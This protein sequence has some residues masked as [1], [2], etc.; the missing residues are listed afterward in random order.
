MADMPIEILNDNPVNRLRQLLLDYDERLAEHERLTQLLAEMDTTI[1]LA[2]MTLSNNVVI[3]LDAQEDYHKFVHNLYLALDDWRTKNGGTRIAPGF[4]D[5]CFQ[6]A[7]L[8]TAGIL[9]G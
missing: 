7:I 9:D 5:Y 2:R 4:V 6:Q 8:K 3:E 1:A